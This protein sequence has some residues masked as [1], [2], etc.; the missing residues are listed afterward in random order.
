MRAVFVVL[1]PLLAGC[2]AA[3]LTLSG[4]IQSKCTDTGLEGCPALADGITSYVDGDK[5]GGLEKIQLGVSA[6]V[7]N[8]ERVK[9]FVLGLRALRKAPGVGPYIA[10]AEPVID[11]IDKAADKAIADKAARAE[12]GIDSAPS[13]TTAKTAVVPDPRRDAPPPIA[14][15]NKLRARTV[16]AAETAN[17]T[18]CAPLATTAGTE[19][20]SNALCFRGAVGPLVVTDLEIPSGCASNLAVLAGPDGKASWFLIASDGQGLSIHGAAFIVAEGEELRVA[21]RRRAVAP[22]TTKGDRAKP[23]EA[24][25]ASRCT[26]T[27]AGVRL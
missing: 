13:K 18:V 25:D 2:G 7:E 24:V 9:L 21:V 26:V 20:G 4:P 12:S 23:V 14:E 15:E 1:G 3:Q 27:W 6:N 5:A 19:W 10:Q 8:P 11:V 17:A 22:P 16:F